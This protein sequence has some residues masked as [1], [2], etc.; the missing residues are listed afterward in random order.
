MQISYKRQPYT[1]QQRLRGSQ[2]VL[3]PAS[4]AQSDTR[5]TDDQDVEG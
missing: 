4:V 2:N 5:P 3:K 1:N